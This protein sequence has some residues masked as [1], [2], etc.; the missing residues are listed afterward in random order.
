MRGLKITFY[1]TFLLAVASIVPFPAEQQYLLQALH[2]CFDFFVIQTGLFLDV[3]VKRM[4][5]ILGN[6]VP[7]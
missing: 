5:V 3:F 2:A 4:D 6:H 1:P 7:G